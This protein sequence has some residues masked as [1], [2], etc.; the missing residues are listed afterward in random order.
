MIDVKDLAIDNYAKIY[1]GEVYQVQTIYYDM[2]DI[3][4]SEHS[5]EQIMCDRIYPIEVTDE[6]LNKIGFHKQKIFITELPSPWF[7]LNLNEFN[8]KIDNCSTCKDRKW[9]CQ[10]YDDEELLGSFDFNYL[11]ELQNGIRLITQNSL[12]V[13][14]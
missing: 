9:S 5:I 6:I 11:H 10:I 14:L 1:T 2:V 12:E 3:I 13:E 8:I 4:N 7:V